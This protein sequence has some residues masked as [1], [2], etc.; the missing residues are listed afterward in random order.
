MSCVMKMH[1]SSRLIHCSTR[2]V[3]PPREDIVYRSLANPKAKTQKTKT[4]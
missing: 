4:G 2:K 1:S 3:R